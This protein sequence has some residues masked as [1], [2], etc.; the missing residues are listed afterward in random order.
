MKRIE[1]IYPDLHLFDGQWLGTSNYQPLLDSIGTIWL[2][3]DDHDYQGDSRLLYR[4]G[5]RVGLLIFGWGSCSGCDALQGCRS[6]AEIEEL[7]AHL[8]DKIL[9]FESEWH[10]AGWVRDHDWE[11]DVGGFSRLGS[12][13]RE[14]VDRALALL[15]PPTDPNDLSMFDLFL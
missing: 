7:R 13:S 4:D 5:D 9:W 11:A 10:A 1:Q 15:A 8:V 14:F 2:Q 3:V 12:S 6:V